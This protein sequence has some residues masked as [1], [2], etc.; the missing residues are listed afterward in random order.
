MKDVKEIL[1]ALGGEG[2]RELI[3]GLDNLSGFGGTHDLA[4]AFVKK[5]KIHSSDGFYDECPLKWITWFATVY[6]KDDRFQGGAGITDRIRLALI[7]GAL[8]VFN[9]INNERHN[10]DYSGEK[11]PN[12]IRVANKS[13]LASYRHLSGEIDDNQLLASHFRAYKKWDGGPSYTDTKD[14]HRSSSAYWLAI[15]AS[16]SQQEHYC[17]GLEN[18][19]RFT[20]GTQ[21]RLETIYRRILPDMASRFAPV[22]P[23]ETD[24][25]RVGFERVGIREM[26]K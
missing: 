9:L 10:T 18:Y 2:Q 12:R 14:A 15:E 24:E 17:S 23:N 6:G 1:D 19:N 26:A 20:P 21:K 22:L 8:E 4:I 7:L 11:T 16:G 25:I 5:N 13:L 3:K